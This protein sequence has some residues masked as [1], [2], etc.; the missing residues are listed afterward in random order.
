[1]ALGV[2]ALVVASLFAVGLTRLSGEERTDRANLPGEHRALIK[3]SL[4]TQGGRQESTEILIPQSGKHGLVTQTQDDAPVATPEELPGDGGSRNAAVVEAATQQRTPERIS[5]V[6]PPGGAALPPAKSETPPGQ[7]SDATHDGSEITEPEV[8]QNDVTMAASNRVLPNFE[9]TDPPAAG[10]TAGKMVPADDHPAPP[11][12]PRKEKIAVLLS[13]GR[14]SL[15][16]FRLLTPAGNNAYHYFQE[17]LVLDPGNPHARDGL[18]QIVDRYVKLARRANKRQNPKLA[19]DYLS[20]GLR[21]Q[22]GNGELIALQDSMREPPVTPQKT[23]IRAS[24][25]IEP[26]P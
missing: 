1:M 21:V 14:Q 8:R 24:P 2:A 12:V 18:D 16:Q 13:L 23:I 26:Q 10:D 3:P 6:T 15:R 25:V 22:P 20:R 5:M 4:L 19:R 11:P 9:L 7:A 17:V